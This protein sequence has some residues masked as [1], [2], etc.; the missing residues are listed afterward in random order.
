MICILCIGNSLKNSTVEQHRFE[1]RGS[2]YIATFPPK[3]ACTVFCLPLGVRRCGGPS[4]CIDL[5]HFIQV[6]WTSVD[7][8]IFGVSCSQSPEDTQEQPLGS[9]KLYIDF[10]PTGFKTDCF[11][12]LWTEGWEVKSFTERSVLM[13]GGPQ[14][15]VEKNCIW[16]VF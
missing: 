2:T 16:S 7:L 8:S 6:T 9:Q 1:L 14:V 3:N 13:G 12:L 4:V 11:F 10:L 5:H 15:S